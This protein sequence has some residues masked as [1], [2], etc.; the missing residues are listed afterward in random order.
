MDR[1]QAMTVFVAVVDSGG[2]AAAARKLE[3][4]P[5]VVTRAVAELE[6]R[7]GLRLLTRTTRVVRVTDAGAR[8]AADCRR[9]LADIDEAEVAATGTHAAPRGTLTITAPVLFGQ[10]YVTPLLVRYLQAHPQVDAQC[11]FLDR[12]VN[13]VEEGIDVA[14]RIGELPDSSLQAV[15]VGR[16]RRMLVASPEYLAEAGTPQHPRELATGHRLVSAG[17]NSPVADWRFVE[18]GRPLVLPLPV[19]MRTTTNDAAIAAARAHF[20]I[21]RLLSYQAAPWLREGTLVPVLEAFETPPLP[22]HVVHLEGRRAT[23]KVR[24]FIDLAVEGLRANPFLN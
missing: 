20:G 1:L 12:V 19:R 17:I 7:L 23:Q 16:V 15:R 10:L 3:L 6:D 9:I 22:I 13:I 21:A 2:F 18:G 4:S 24:G 5:P 14:V 11:L 8:Y